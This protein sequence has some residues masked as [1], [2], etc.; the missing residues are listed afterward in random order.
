MSACYVCDFGVVSGQCSFKLGK[1]GSETFKY[2]KVDFGEQ[3]VGKTQVVDWISEFKGGVICGDDD[4]HSVRRLRA[5]EM[6]MR[7]K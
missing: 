3:T 2:W 7:M 6:K 5:K 1:I 4:E